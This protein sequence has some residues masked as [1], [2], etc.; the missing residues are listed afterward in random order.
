MYSI[1][2][3]VH[4]GKKEALLQALNGLRKDIDFEFQIADEQ[5]VTDPGTDGSGKARKESRAEN[6][7]TTRHS[8][9]T[10]SPVVVES[11]NAEDGEEKEPTP[12]EIA[13]ELNQWLDRKGVA[14]VEFA[15][16]INR[17]K[18][19]FA[20]MLNHPPS[21]LPKGFAKEAWLKM[22]KFLQDKIAQKEFLDKSGNKKRKKSSS[23]VTGEELEPPKKRQTPTTF[24]KWQ[25]VMLD[26]IFVKC[27]G[28][29][30]KS[31]IKR[32]CPTVKLEQRQV[33]ISF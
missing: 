1:Q 22:H 33:N 21:S 23:T 7:G 10:T 13:T 5:S 17:S 8:N 9:T 11:S 15:K 18:S 20:D 2:I 4:E 28:R 12:N 14:R 25:T 16:Y 19:T 30:E 6:T 29:P 27:G 26:G 24:E 3:R 32:I 31:T